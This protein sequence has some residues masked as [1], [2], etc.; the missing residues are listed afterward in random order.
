MAVAV[1]VAVFP[2]DGVLVRVGDGVLVWVGVGL[3]VEVAVDVATCACVGAIA[4]V[5]STTAA[6]P[7]SPSDTHAFLTRVVLINLLPLLPRR[8]IRGRF[9]HNLHR[10]A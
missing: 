5:P 3:A 9:R 6:I 4:T 2:G 10:R 1:R 8:G 7:A